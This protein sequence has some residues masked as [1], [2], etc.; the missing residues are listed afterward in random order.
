VA[1]DH[2][3]GNLL[4]ALESTSSRMSRAAREEIVLGRSVGNEEIVAE[5]D[6][7]DPEAVRALAE[8]I[9]AGARP[10]LAAVGRATRLRLREEDLAA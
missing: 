5:L 9:V 2:L 1:R 4:L 6:R 3:K 8:R 10:A 7:V